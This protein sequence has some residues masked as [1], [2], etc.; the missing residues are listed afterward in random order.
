VYTAADLRP[1]PVRKLRATGT[2]PLRLLLGSFLLLISA[3]TLLLELPISTPPGADISWIDALFTSTSA[4]CVT[5]LVVRDTGTGFTLFGQAVILALI[6]LGGLGIMTFGLFVFVL[7]RGR[8]SLAHRS[9]LE[10][11]LTGQGGSAS[12][13]VMPLLRLVFRFTLLCEGIGALLLWP[14]FWIDLGPVR[15]AWH[16]VFHS[17]SAF[18]NAGFALWPDSL[19]RYRADPLVNG[20]V[21]ALLVLG[22]LGFLVVYELTVMAR[23]KEPMSVHTKMVLTVSG[24]LLLAGVAGFWIL[25]RNLALAGRTWG[26]QLLISLFQGAT[27]RTAGFNTVDIAGLAPSTEFLIILLMFVGGSPGSTAG[28]IKT[29]TLGVLTLAVWSRLRGRRNVNAFGRT[30]SNGTVR[31]TLSIALVGA[32]VLVLGLFA[33]L[34]V[35]SPERLV[36]EN[37]SVFFGYLFETVSALGTV[38][39]STGVTPRL[40]EAARVLVALFMLLGRLGP[41]TVG[42]AVA[43]TEPLDDWSYP[44][45]DVMVG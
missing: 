23:R 20:V 33:L 17:V 10:R 21:I 38:G 28:G 34:L 40:S 8:M 44:E 11:T 31:D 12:A 36:R 24:V 45:E 6:Q 30:L 19:T 13:E 42:M 18:C 27:P 26:E 3:G 29:T 7:F 22:G 25:E 14:R 4:T 35:E 2:D 32:L 41:L 9:V 5:G 43:A 15:G 39:L 1:L 16:A 37:Q